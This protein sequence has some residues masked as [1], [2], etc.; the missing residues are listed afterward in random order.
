M[1]SFTLV[2]A[3]QIAAIRK[4]LLKKSAY[5]VQ[6]VTKAKLSSAKQKSNG[7]FMV[8]HATQ[9]VILSLGIS[10]QKK[11]YL[12]GRPQKKRFKPQRNNKKTA[13]HTCEFTGVFLRDL[14]K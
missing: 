4:Q 2:H 9:T 3:S 5:H 8:V 1:G 13:Q 10:Q 11:H 7:R 14:K 12:T 6:N